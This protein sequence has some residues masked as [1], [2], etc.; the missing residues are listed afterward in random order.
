MTLKV[1]NRIL[2][3][4]FIASLFCI[5]T[6][7]LCF[8]IAFVNKAITPPPDI[9]IPAFVTKFAFF[10]YSFAAT[11]I[12][13]LLIMLYATGAVFICRQFFENTQ[14]S[15]IIFFIGVV[16]GC[17]CEGVRFLTPLYGLWSSFSDFLFF[18]GRIL[19]TGRIMVPLS[20][21][22]A[23]VASSSEMRQD[24]ERNLLTIVAIGIV[25]ALI[26]PLNTAKISSAG[27]V[28]WGFPRLFLTV[29][30]LFILIA[31]VSFY[32]NGSKQSA[33]EYKTLAWTMLLIMAGYG[34]L[35]C[36]DNFLFMIAGVPLLG[37][38]TLY[39]LKTLHNL[40]MWK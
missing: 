8:I 4:F 28:T 18:C 38:G 19:F 11:M 32:I 29:R 27:A 37:C 14:T 20:F 24:V 9:R 16:A 36:A 17:L 26:V 6:A 13:I 5:A 25:F 3:G 2:Q 22:F 23:A 15:E 12:S 39:Y 30:C 40:Y 31:F 1:R 21:V 33:P 7:V 10:K 35:T 34:F